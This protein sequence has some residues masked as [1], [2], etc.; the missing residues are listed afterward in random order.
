MGMDRTFLSAHVTHGVRQR[1]NPLSEKPDLHRLP[2]RYAF[3]RIANASSDFSAGTLCRVRYVAQIIIESTYDGPSL[4]DDD[5]GCHD[6]EDK[7]PDS[8][9][10]A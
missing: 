2:V 3:G 7:A 10:N 9:C 4:G 6:H 5:E 8:G 1:R